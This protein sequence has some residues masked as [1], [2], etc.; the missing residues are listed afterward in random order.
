MV[1]RMNDILKKKCVKWIYF[2]EDK[3]YNMSK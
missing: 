2:F 3:V 1:V